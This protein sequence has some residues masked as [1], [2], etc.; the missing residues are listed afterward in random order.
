MKA[1]NDVDDGKPDDEE[2]GGDFRYYCDKCN[3]KYTDWKELQKHK[4]DCVKI[5]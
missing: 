4:Y 2:Y 5:P 3:E 1:E